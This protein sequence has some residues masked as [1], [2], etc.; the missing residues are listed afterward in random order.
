MVSLFTREWIEIASAVDRQYSKKGLPLYEGV[1]WNVSSVLLCG[2]IPQSPSLRGSGLKSLLS[3][4]C[5]L[6]SIGLP[7]YEGVDWNRWDIIR[8]NQKRCLPLYEGV[9][10]NCGYAAIRSATFSVSL[11]T[12]EWIEMNR[13]CKPAPAV[14]LPLY[15][16]VDWNMV[17]TSFFLNCS[18]SPSLRGSGLKWQAVMSAKSLMLSPSLR[19]S[20]L[21]YTRRIIRIFYVQSPSLRGS[22]LKLSANQHLSNQVLSPSLRGSGLKFF[23]L[24]LLPDSHC[25]PLYEGVD[26]N[27]FG[28]KKSV[29]WKGLPLYEGVDWNDWI[30][31][32]DDAGI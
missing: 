26:W 22:G 16:G 2:A 6:Q 5:P 28:K 18:T 21:K 3:S 10:W 25:L 30:G 27:F 1:D 12:R 31:C 20:G 32:N 8:I 23:C 19:G 29:E 11:F 7:L 14:R 9:D 4:Q 24:W 15:E 17:I 13:Y